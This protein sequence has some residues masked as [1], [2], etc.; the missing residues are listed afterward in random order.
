MPVVSITIDAA[1]LAAHPALCSPL[2]GQQPPHGQY[3]FFTNDNNRTVDNHALGTVLW[4]AHNEAPELAQRLSAAIHTVACLGTAW[5]GAVDM[6]G[7]RAPAFATQANASRMMANLPHLQAAGHLMDDLCRMLEGCGTTGVIM[8]PPVLLAAPG[9]AA[10]LAGEPPLAALTKA[11]EDCSG[12]E[13]V[14]MLTEA[15]KAV[16]VNANPEEATLHAT[17]YIRIQ[18]DVELILRSPACHGVPG[19]VVLAI[20][21]V[22]EIERA[23]PASER[24][25][26]LGLVANTS[27]SANLSDFALAVVASAETALA[28]SPDLTV[29]AVTRVALNAVQQATSRCIA[30]NNKALSQ[31]A[32]LQRELLGPQQAGRQRGTPQGKGPTDPRP[33]ARAQ[34]DQKRRR[35]QPSDDSK[36]SGGAAEAKKTE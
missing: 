19:L 29:H 2:T 14:S 4:D 1:F 32:K 25:P 8:P 27:W 17:R 31:C 21:C 13:H 18:S 30:A 20:T 28:A 11:N 9:P 26:G 34:A 36:P 3:L 6:T 16:A 22:L 33:E 35:K 24:L 5:H 23:T 10:P 12:R 15:M 7:Q